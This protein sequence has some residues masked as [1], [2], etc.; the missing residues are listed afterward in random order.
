MRARFFAK[1]QGQMP[2]GRECARAKRP[3]FLYK[4][5]CSWIRRNWF[6]SCIRM[7]M[8]SFRC[9]SPARRQWIS[10]F[11]HRICFWGGA[12]LVLLMIQ[13]L[14]ASNL[15]LSSKSRPESLAFARYIE[16]LQ[17]PDPFTQAGPVGLLVESSLPH[18][19]KEARLLAIRR[20]GENARSEYAIVGVVGDGSALD[21]VAIRYFA[22]QEEIESL[23]ISSMQISPENYTFRLLGQVK[24]GIGNA[25]V[26]DITPR[27]HRRGLFKGQIWIEAG[28]GAEVLISGRLEGATSIG[29][30]VDF[31]RETRL[32][33]PGYARVTH[34]TFTVPLLGRSE[35][36]VTER[37]LAGQDVIQMPQA[38]PKQ[39]SS[40]LDLCRNSDKLNAHVPGKRQDLGG[41]DIRIRKGE[42]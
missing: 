2:T 15:S 14:P 23:P 25:Y 27:K 30:S 39:E 5:L 13:R 8:I 20:M 42:F 35:L 36:V 12:V 19:Y 32:D 6:I 31:V 38:L 26:Y 41:C 16:S 29:S 37:P 11:T 7:G 21:E 17:Q 9:S 28:T 24:T 34:L 10:A 40:M 4:M 33:G 1:C 3:P 22:L 18:L